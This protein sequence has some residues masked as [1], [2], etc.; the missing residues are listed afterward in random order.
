MMNINFFK[1]MLVKNN[2]LH[3]NPIDISDNNIP[4]GNSVYLM[5]CNK[6]KKYYW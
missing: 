3:V 5:V 1:K 6:L 4:N 2:D